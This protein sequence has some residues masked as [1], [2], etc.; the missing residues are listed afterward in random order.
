MYTSVKAQVDAFL[1][2]FHELIPQELVSIFNHKEL[3]LLIAGLPDFD[4][5]WIFVLNTFSIP[6]SF[7]SEE[8]H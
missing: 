1:A 4:S 5:K 7:G 8:V 6:N 3:E 2:G